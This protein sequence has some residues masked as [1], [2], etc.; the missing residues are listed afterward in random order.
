MVRFKG[1]VTPAPVTP[2]LV[3]QKKRNGVWTTTSTAG[4]WT[5]SASGLTFK[6]KV[7][8]GKSGEFRL[9]AQDTAGKY[10]VGAGRV[11]SIKAPK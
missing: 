6:K 10:A 5:A 3:V 4:K 9:V 11:L 8:I 7:R 1:T 2:S